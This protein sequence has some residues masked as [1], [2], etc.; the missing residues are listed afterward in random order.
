MVK[1]LRLYSL[2]WLPFVLAF[3][4][5]RLMKFLTLNGLRYQSEFLDLTFVLNTGVAFSLLSFL[6]NSLKYLNLVF[7]LVLFLYLFWQKVFL[8]EHKVAFGLMLGAG[9]S[10]LLDRFLYGGVVDMFFWHKWFEFAIFNVADVLINMSVVLLL[11]QEFC[12]KKKNDRI[13]K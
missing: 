13:D 10:N 5:D 3:T 11:V 2:F 1:F 12:R 7:I 4:L 6:D 9:S 8:Q